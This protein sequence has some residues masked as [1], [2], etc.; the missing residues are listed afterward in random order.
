MPE[1]EAVMAVN[2]HA[3]VVTANGHADPLVEP[4]TRLLHTR[5]RGE[6]IFS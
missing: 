3:L 4:A 6:M 2:E 1:P 5:P